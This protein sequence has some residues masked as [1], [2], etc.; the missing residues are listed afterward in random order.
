MT[1]RSSRWL[2]LA[3]LLLATGAASASCQ[4]EK[5]RPPSL[6]NSTSST[7]S[8]STTGGMGGS[9][10]DATGGGGAGGS[11]GATGTGGFPE[12]CSNGLKD[13]DETDIDCGNLCAPCELGKGCAVPEDCSTKSCQN[14]LCAVATCFDSIQNQTETDVDCGAAPCPLCLDD[15]KCTG[16][17]N[18]QSSV[19]TDGKC[20]KE[21]CDDG[22]WNGTET[23]V[24]CGSTCAKKCGSGQKCGQV[25]DCQSKVCLAGACVCPLNMVN[26]PVPGG[27]TYCVDVA[28][29]SFLEYKSFVDSGPNPMNQSDVCKGWNNLFLPNDA[30]TPENFCDP[31]TGISWCDA[32]A[33]CQY[34]GKHL[35][36]KIGGGPN[37]PADLAQP[38]KSEW[39]NACSLQASLVY[40]Y[41]NVYEAG[42]CNDGDTV[43]PA[44]V[45]NPLP[46]PPLPP[47]CNQPNKVCVGGQLGIHQMSGNVAEWEDSCDGPVGDGA[48]D[49]CLTRGGAYNS[50]E[51]GL[52]CSSPLS[53]PRNYAGP[54]VGFRC[55]Q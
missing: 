3:S 12:T 11:A 1:S 52:K 40:P 16:P 29:V 17:A 10:G 24:D 53:R 34:A 28:E 43:I 39:F 31:V 48:G 25:A 18:C 23:D 15:K 37:A 47:T 26:M 2:A 46:S 51:M 6:T 21:S 38:N 7:T 22:V 5:E 20:A 50:D 36:G 13:E 45:S 49:S 8:T 44:W 33:Y 42:T 9:G 19:C 32:Y 54:D 55:C 4:K 41:G 35:C 30:F 27:G 14:M